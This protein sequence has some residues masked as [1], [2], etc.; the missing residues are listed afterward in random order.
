MHDNIYSIP[1]G[2]LAIYRLLYVIEVGLRE[3]IIE[4]F[5]AKIGPGLWKHRLPGDVLKAYKDGRKYERNIKW[6]NLV[7]HHPLYYVEFP[8]LKKVIER[9][10]NWQ[11]A[12]ES[13]FGNKEIVHSTLTEL[14][15]IRNKI[16]HNRKATAG[17]L[18]VVEASYQKIVS[19]IGEKRLS[20]LVSRCSQ[21]NDL[22]ERFLELRQ[23][24]A[25]TFAACI[26][27]MPV[28]VL[29]VWAKTYTAWWFEAD[30]LGHSVKAVKVFFET[31]IAYSKIPRPRG[32]GH[33]IKRWVQSNNLDHLYAVAMG[34]LETVLN[35]IGEK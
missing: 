24:A 8:D 21:A 19:A 26:E 14:E 15:P 4:L 11:E 6:C 32:S 35:E 3:L 34:E 5:N 33:K 9:S 16:A 30:Y 27:C 10:D 22:R 7:P 20:E 18:R 12:F 28:G 13:V 25:V 2:N 17:D 23:E 31:A 1:E 29:D